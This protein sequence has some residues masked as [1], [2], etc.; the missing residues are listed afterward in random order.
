MKNLL[1]ISCVLAI[2]L[3]VSMSVK[4]ADPAGTITVT[5]V[6]T[7]SIDLTDAGDVAL[8]YDEFG[9]LDTPSATKPVHIKANVDWTLAI[10]TTST[11]FSS[12][13]GK[14]FG[15]DKVSYTLGSI[16]TGNLAATG[17]T[18]TQF[19]EF[20]GSIVW[21]LG[22]LE[23]QYAGIYTANVTYTLAQV[24]TN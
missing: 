1:K 8:A 16:L 20:S 12:V 6:K 24:G 17:T 15:L 3:F 22:A 4:A 23:H 19:G 10:S 18:E 11:N 5:C 9:S 2:A 21:N 13:A 14:T 7:L